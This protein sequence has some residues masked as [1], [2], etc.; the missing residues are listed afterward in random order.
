MNRVKAEQDKIINDYKQKQ[1][2]NRQKG[3]DQLQQM[4]T[5]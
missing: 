1:Q 3:I 5:N 4:K 2:M